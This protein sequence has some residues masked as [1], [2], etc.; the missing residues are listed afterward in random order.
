M[1]YADRVEVH[2]AGEIPELTADVRGADGTRN[3]TFEQ[4]P[5]GTGYYPC[6]VGA[7]VENGYYTAGH[8]G[9]TGD[10]IRWAATF[11]TQLGVV[12]ASAIPLNGG[13]LGMSHG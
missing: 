12:Q 4:K 1:Q 8:C 10:D 13:T 9:E 3:Y 6:S 2:E 5:L 7:T 11:P